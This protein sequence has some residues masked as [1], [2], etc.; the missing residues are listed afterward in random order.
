MGNTY[1]QYDRFTP[2]EISLR[3]M[4]QPNRPEKNAF[5]GASNAKL[6]PEQLDWAVSIMFETRSPQQLTECVGK[7]APLRGDYIDFW[8]DM[9]NKFAGMPGTK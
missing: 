9:E 2:G 8:I 3:N 5:E 4:M 1:G 6:G 7:N